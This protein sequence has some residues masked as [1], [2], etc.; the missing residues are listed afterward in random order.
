MSKENQIEKYEMFQN[1][2]DKIT[3][4]PDAAVVF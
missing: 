3:K 4:L 2:D 1:Q